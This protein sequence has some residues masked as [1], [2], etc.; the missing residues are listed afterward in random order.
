MTFG[1]SLYHTEFCNGLALVICITSRKVE[2]AAAIESNMQLSISAHA[3]DMAS[4][5]KASI[6]VKNMLP[7]PSPPA[8]LGKMA[9]GRFSGL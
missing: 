7:H 6:T 2:N 9:T 1:C 5:Y 4:P 3:V 8:N